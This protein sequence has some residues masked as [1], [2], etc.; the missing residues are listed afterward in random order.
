MTTMVKKQWCTNGEELIEKYFTM[1]PDMYKAIAKERNKNH[2]IVSLL[3][4]VQCLMAQ[5]YESLV[6]KQQYDEVF[7]KKATFEHYNE[8]LNDIK[9]VLDY[10]GEVK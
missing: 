3:S 5:M 9:C 7:P 1:M 2:A 4:D 8:L 10:E 6:A